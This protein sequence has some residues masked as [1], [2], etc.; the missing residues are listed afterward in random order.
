[1]K[2]LQILSLIVVT[3]IG[4]YSSSSVA[5]PV[6]DPCGTAMDGHFTASNP[7]DQW[8]DVVG[9][10]LTARGSFGFSSFTMGPAYQV[11]TT[12]LHTAAAATQSSFMA[13]RGSSHYAGLFNEVFPGRGNGDVDKWEFWVYRTGAVWL[14]SITWTPAIW[15][16]LQA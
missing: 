3:S 5:Q 4:L 15:V 6:T 7:P 8:L 2:A 14:R 13:S 12:P 11:A 1:M 16:Q 10:R 9:T